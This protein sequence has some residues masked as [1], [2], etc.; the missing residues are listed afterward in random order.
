VLINFGTSRIED[1][2]IDKGSIAGNMKKFLPL[3]ILVLFNLIVGLIVL[4]DF[5]QSTDEPYQH[6]YAENTIRAAEFIFK[7]GEFSEYFFKEKPK[8]GSHGPA[9]IML[10]TLLRKVFLP[11][12]T[13]LELLHFSHYLYFVTFQLGVVAIYF[14]ARRWMS[15]GAAFGTAL[16]FNTQP[17]LVGHAFMN[18]KDVVFMSLLAAS[19]ALGLWMIDRSDKE[20]VLTDSKSVRAGIRSIF[21]QLLCIDVWLAS[22][23]LGFTSAIR[24]VAP[25]IG[26]VA[27]VHMVITRKWH[28]WPRLVAYGLLAFGFMILFWPYLW[29]DPFG[30]LIASIGHCVTY[31]GTHLTL[32]RGVVYDANELPRSYL[33][34][35]LAIQLTEPTIL[36]IV[37]G[38][39]A[40]LKKLK[41]DLVSLV[42]IWFAIPFVASILLGVNLYNNFRQ[43]F[44][45]LPPLFLL[46]GLALDWVLMN[47]RRPIVYFLILLSA[48]APGVYANVLL[49][50]YQ[51]VYY[52]Q[53]VGGVNGAFRRFELDYWDLAYLEAQNYIN[54][55]V[56]P[57]ANVYVGDSKL[58]VE[59]FKC[60]GLNFN[61][62]GNQKKNWAKYDYMII[63]TTQ[64]L[65]EKFAE[66]QTVFKVER[67]GVPLVLVK[68]GAD[69]E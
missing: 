19:A 18:P 26:V 41:W 60:P 34:V 21:R 24:L 3:A 36:F 35:L 55:V 28:A 37:I 31:P 14:L 59:A 1:D 62:F 32:F 52:N 10:V 5:G 66:F 13:P 29:P 30:R 56:G 25:L 61:T 51:Y 8:Q 63:S 69:R 23:A 53:L 22:F 4:P 42:A 12:G 2:I 20:A 65:D 15:E 33:P 68:K 39:F 38:T 50:P 7:T 67:D 54:Q 6:G 64:N 17:L 46:A 43:M 9:F 44:F 16:L 57:N 58:T 47:S 45:I 40:L 27:L 48:L 49:H 11:Q